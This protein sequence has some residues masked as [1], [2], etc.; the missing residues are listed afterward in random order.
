MINN[1][2]IYIGTKSSSASRLAPL[3]LVGDGNAYSNFVWEQASSGNYTP[4]GSNKDQVL[5][6]PDVAPPTFFM[7]YSVIGPNGSQSAEG[8]PVANI[9][10]EIGGA[11][12]IVYSA[13]SWFRIASC[14]TNGAPVSAAVGQTNYLWS[15]TNV[16]SDCS[17]SVTFVAAT[18]EQ[19]GLEVPPAW[20]S[21]YYVTEAAALADANIA[22]DY[23]L[24]LNPT[25][26]YAI[27]LM[28]NSITVSGSSISNVVQLTDGA[29][30]LDT[31]INGR[32]VLQ[33]K[34]S[35]LDATWEDIGSATI[36]NA[37]FGADGTYGVLFTDLTN[38]FFQAVIKP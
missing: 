7:I 1:G 14:L 35:L 30:P 29:L 24:N 38:S 16:Q 5:A 10:V 15:V 12:S 17:N 11:T 18:Q 22:T 27:E 25:G 36:S 34:M 8:S 23:L 3:H 4:G 28:I 2:Y 20:A 37:N 6:P 19:T 31:T 21:G 32:L 33:G 13:A 9:Q 26:T